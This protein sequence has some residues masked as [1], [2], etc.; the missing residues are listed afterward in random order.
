MNCV[1]RSILAI[2]LC[3]TVGTLSATATNLGKPVTSNSLRIVA[4]GG[5]VTK[6]VFAL[7]SGDRVVGYPPSR[8]VLSI[9]DLFN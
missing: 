5:A 9:S 7:G 4:L 3:N 8:Y 2:V 1:L 6:I